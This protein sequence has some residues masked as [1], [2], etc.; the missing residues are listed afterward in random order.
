VLEVA[1]DR[2][3]GLFN[4][5]INPQTMDV[6]QEQFEQGVGDRF[7]DWLSQTSGTPCAFLRRADRAP[8]LVYAYRGIE[9]LVEITAA[10]YDGKHAEFLWKAARGV[11]DAPDAW[12][13]V[14]ADKSL[15]AAIAMRIS[16][17]AQKRYGE[18]TVLLIE[19]PPGVTTVERLTALLVNQSNDALTLFSGIF[20]VGTFPMTSS[21]TGG[22]RVIPL[23]ALD[24][25]GDS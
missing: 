6:I 23:K 19:V 10:Y 22:Y 1:L 9:I 2:Q 11:A 25:T 5:L 18:N 24:I 3:I 21:S 17:K 12:T 16:E 14:N 15:A 13:G 8:D 7:A 4:K 20:V